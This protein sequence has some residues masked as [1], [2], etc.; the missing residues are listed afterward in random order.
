VARRNSS[1]VFFC[2]LISYPAW[3]YRSFRGIEEEGARKVVRK[4]ALHDQEGFQCRAITMWDS[5]SRSREPLQCL[6]ERGDRLLW[7][8]QRIRGRKH[9]LQFSIAG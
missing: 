1:P 7:I 6:L 8:K 9:R 4:Q 5:P 2:R 3:N